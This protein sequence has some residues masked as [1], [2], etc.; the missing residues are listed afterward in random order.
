MSAWL[1][2]EV[3]LCVMWLGVTVSVGKRGKV[4]QTSRGVVGRKGGKSCGCLERVPKN[5]FA[6][7]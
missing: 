6:S 1:E 7:G 3:I 2:K 5:I 4:E